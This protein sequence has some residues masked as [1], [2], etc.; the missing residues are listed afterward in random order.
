MKRILQHIDG[1]A[2]ELA[3]H[4]MFELL[5]DDSVEPLERL[6]FAPA[7]AHFIMSYADLCRFFL[8]DAAPSDRF[9]ELANINLVEESE[10]Y[11]WFLADLTALGL[12]A[13]L[14]FTST[15]RFLWGDSTRKTRILT[16][17]FCKLSATMTSLEKLV[18][19][20]V[21]EAAGKV[22]LDVST[23]VG[24]RAAEK[25]GRKLPYFGG[26]HLESEE[27]HTLAEGSV[28]GA[29]SEVT[30]DAAAHAR[31]TA[32]VDK[33]FALFVGQLDDAV[34]FAT[35]EGREWPARQRNR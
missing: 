9:A 28:R 24:R 15:L 19:I 10:H 17:E 32:L 3:K 2:G 13:E 14:P 7:V 30:L 27:G 33:L 29:L 4:A 8:Q 21:I 20:L 26:Q 34:A 16:Y 31:A 5:R 22:A 12:D 18:L 25:L 1:C 35:G 6:G 23:P 11:R